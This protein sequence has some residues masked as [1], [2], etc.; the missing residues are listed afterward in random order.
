MK[1]E[2]VYITASV[3]GNKIKVEEVNGFFNSYGSIAELM[4]GL[5]DYKVEKVFMADTQI[6][7]SY[8]FDYAKREKKK[9]TKIITRGGSVYSFTMEGVRFVSCDYI[10]NAPFTAL[11]RELNLG[12]PSGKAVHKLVGYIEDL[13]EDKFSF[14]NGDYSTIGALSW[15]WL[16]QGFCGIHTDVFGAR[17]NNHFN[18]DDW[19]FFKKKHIYKGGLCLLNSKYRGKDM[20]NLYKY[21]KNS[22]FLWVMVSGN[23]P[24]GRYVKKKGKPQSLRDKVI[25]IR[26]NGIT[27]FPGIAALSIG[28]QPMEDFVDEDLWLWGDELEELMNWYDFDVEWIEYLEWQVN[29]PDSEFRK[30]AL[31]FFPQKSAADGIRRRG[32]KLIINNSYGKW[33]ENPVRSHFNYDKGQLTESKPFILYKSGVRSLAVASKI[34]ALARTELLRSIR[35]ACRNQPDKY[36][37]YGD[38]DSMILTIPLGEDEIGENLGDFKFEGRWEKGVFL[39]KKCYLLYEEKEGYEAH[40]CG[41]NRASLQ[42]AM[43][44]KT[45]EEV[46]QFFDYDKE[47]MCPAIVSGEG[48]KYRTLVPRVISKGYTNSNFNSISNAYEEGGI[49]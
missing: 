37:V 16:S 22:F 1:Y 32:V 27:K 2:Y 10:Y 36:F 48:G 9:L 44:G 23:M 29:K 38:T 17:Y 46:R 3:R 13:G 33:G 40:A 8:L 39:G 41:V 34:T 24:C 30:F 43:V 21:D 28:V 35:T 31:H 42:A 6:Q 47:F 4:F 18:M 19:D 25:H 26:G 5:R 11:C 45:W 20:T 12:N 49:L 15:K 14:I 7:F